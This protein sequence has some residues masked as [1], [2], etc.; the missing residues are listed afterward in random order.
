MNMD[1][2]KPICLAVLMAFLAP[3]C[4][5]PPASEMPPSSRSGDTLKSQTPVIPPGDTINPPQPGP[6]PQEDW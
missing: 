4:M 2:C 5:R 6:V 3:G 1:P